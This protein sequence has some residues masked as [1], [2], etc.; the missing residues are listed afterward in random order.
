MGRMV[1]NSAAMKVRLRRIQ[2]EA[3]GITSFEFVS[4]DG[5]QLPA[6]SAGAH[7]DLFLPDEI[8]RSYSLVNP[9]SEV[10]RYTVAVQREPNGRGGS[11][12]MH[13]VPRVGDVISI[14]QSINDFP[15]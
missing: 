1:S 5:T 2:L 14:S 9:P 7:I 15:L 10:H 3:E 8:V 11:S 13:E 6:F 12:W 4:A